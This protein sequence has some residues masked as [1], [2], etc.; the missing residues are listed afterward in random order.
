[1]TVSQWAWPMAAA[2]VLGAA[3]CATAV[4]PA[5]APFCTASVSSFSDPEAG[6][7]GDYSPNVLFADLTFT[8][9]SVGYGAAGGRSDEITLANGVLHLAR[10][11]GAGGHAERIGAAAG[12][13]AYMLQVVS[14][15]AWRPSVGVEGLASLDD[16]G[17]AIARAAVEAGCAGE[18]KLAYRIEGRIVAAEWSL[19]TLPQRG[20]FTTSNQTA[21]IT[22]LYASVDQARHFVTPG[23]NIHAHIVFPGLGVAGHLKSVILAPRARLMLQGG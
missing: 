20:D 22:G 6:A 5:A 14:P 8:S 11:D 13:G 2:G 3:G 7:R 16:V 12:E 21:V 17:A 18:T 19:D 1:M 9:T 15:R 10:P 23:R 4:A